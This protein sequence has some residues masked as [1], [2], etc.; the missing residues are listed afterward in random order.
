MQHW[1]PDLEAALRAGAAL[2]STQD[3]KDHVERQLSDQPCVFHRNAEI[4][5][6]YGALYLRH[7][8]LF[9]WAGMA[10]HASHHVRVALWP[11]RLGANTSGYVDLPKAVGRWQALRMSDIDRLRQTNNEIFRDVF[12]AHLVYDGSA[13]GLERLEQLLAGEP[14]GAQLLAAFRLLESG[15]SMLAAGDERAEA[16]IWEAN[17]KL[18]R[19]EQEAVVQPNFDRLSCAFAR[20]FSFGA[21]LGFRADGPLRSI[22]FFTSFYGHAVLRRPVGLLRTRRWPMVTHLED[23]WDWIERSI[24]PRFRRYEA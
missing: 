10:A 2:G 3:W 19:H 24:L 15:R 22:G 14:G 1:T 4:T 9:K 21:T 18:L 6:L 7:P 16:A 8:D 13:A 5:A 12:W 20:A 23:R 11:L 17:R